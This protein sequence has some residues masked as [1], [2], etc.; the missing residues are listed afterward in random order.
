MTQSV[1]RS[2]VTGSGD[3]DA[4]YLAMYCVMVAVIGAIPIMCVGSLWAMH[5]DPTHQFHVQD[6]GIGV[7][8]VCGGFAT[9]I[10]AV[11]L[12]RMGDKERAGVMTATAT[13]TTTIDR[14]DDHHDGDR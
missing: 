4:G 9:A 11:G 8:A 5:L 13:Q 7:G 14:H 3:I 6:L 12:F 10:G 1:F 2:A